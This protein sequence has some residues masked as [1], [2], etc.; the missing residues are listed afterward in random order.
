MNIVFTNKP[1]SRFTLTWGRRAVICLGL[2]LIVFLSVWLVSRKLVESH[3]E[4]VS[5]IVQ[6]EEEL[7]PVV[8]DT[9]SAIIAK[10]A[11]EFELTP[12]VMERLS[13]FLINND[14]SG[15]GLYRV[16]LD[17]LKWVSSLWLPDA[18]L[19]LNDP[20]INCTVAFTLLKQRVDAGLTEE[21][22][23]ASYV[24]GAPAAVISNRS[25]QC[26]EMLKFVMEIN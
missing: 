1:T 20:V 9:Y 8:A 25:A 14:F 13:D 19:D 23:I 22:A 18:D 11:L 17:H 5:D 24:Y 26:I 10:M 16:K 4:A 2:V 3:E 7:T 15:T 21:Q 6:S 12:V